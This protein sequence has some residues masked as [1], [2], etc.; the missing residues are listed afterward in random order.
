MELNPLQRLFEPLLPRQPHLLLLILGYLPRLEKQLRV[1]HGPQLF[2][3]ILDVFAFRVVIMCLF[4]TGEYQ[5]G[6][7][8]TT[9]G[10]H[11]RR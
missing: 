4:F 3:P 2:D 11:S 6:I 7:G 10:S 9:M 1:F 8:Q 5:Y